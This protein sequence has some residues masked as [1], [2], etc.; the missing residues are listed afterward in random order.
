MR[1]AYKSVRKQIVFDGILA[2]S[3]LDENKLKEIP[4]EYAIAIY[5]AMADFKI[6]CS[7]LVC[8]FD[9][10]GV[11]HIFSITSPGMATNHDIPGFHA[12]GVGRDIAIGE[13]Y[14]F[15]TEAEE[16][17]DTALYEVFDAKATAELIQ[18][19]G[20]EW[21]CSIL[22]ADRDPVEITRSARKAME[23]MLEEATTSPYHPK[24]G[25]KFDRIPQWK[26][27]L[28][29]FTDGILRP[30]TKSKRRVTA[31]DSVKKTNRHSE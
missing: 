4:D 25:D 3:L 1:D 16:S 17:L 27:T 12:V 14:Q 2:P 18:G 31:K 30:P 6:T 7:L 21:D 5:G 28:K 29:E 20:Y 11:P 24:W 19:V 26:K 23:G 8:G 22:V 10:E 13:L 15:E 9:L